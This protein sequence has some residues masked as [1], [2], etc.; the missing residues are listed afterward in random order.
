MDETAATTHTPGRLL[1]LVGLMP[2][3]AL[4]QSAFLPLGELAGE[5]R[6]S[7]ATGVSSFDAAGGQTAN[8]VVVG[9]SQGPLGREAFRWTMTGGMVGLGDLGGSFFF[10]NGA[11]VNADGG[12]VVGSASSDSGVL[13]YRWRAGTG[14]ESLGDLPGGPTR[15]EAAAISADGQVVV[16]SSRSAGGPLGDEAFLWTPTLGMVG[17]GR[18][19]ADGASD[20]SDVNADG[21]IIVGTSGQDSQLGTAFRWTPTGGME[22]LA[23]F[24]GEF[25]GSSALGISADGSTI[26]GW[27]IS[28]ED[29]LAARWTD[30]GLES[31]GAPPPFENSNLFA[32]AASEDGSVIVGYGQDG[33]MLRP[34]YWT[35][36]GGMRRLAEVFTDDF[37]LDLTGWTLTLALDVTVHGDSGRTAIVG[38]GVNPSG[39]TEAFLAV[40]DP[41]PP[42][43]VDLDGDGSLTIFDF[44]TFQNAFDAMDPAADFDGDGQFTIFDFLAFSNAF[45]AGCP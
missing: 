15:S 26:V 6:F 2:A 42:C 14:M 34:F 3:A 29:Q 22:A 27:A 25:L 40:L 28:G 36:D 38:A 35:Q 24:P 5:S 16:G 23:Q 33:S 32:Q 7:S 45:D 9:N 10:S 41:D 30:S 8:L 17:L 31:L 19:F 44:I 18:L 12:F 4:A 11:A 20:A 21:S 1:L 13:A 37:G 43:R 39:Q